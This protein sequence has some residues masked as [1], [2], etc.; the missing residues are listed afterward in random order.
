MSL[1]KKIKINMEP[2]YIELI[3]I[4]EAVAN[5]IRTEGCSCCESEEHPELREKIAEL[6]HVTKYEDGSGY[7]FNQYASEEFKV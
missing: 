3:K 6:L 4:R 1:T 2:E 5:Y 7:N